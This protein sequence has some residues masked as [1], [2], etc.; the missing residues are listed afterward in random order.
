MA[1]SGNGPADE[2]AD[3]N[4][5]GTTMPRSTSSG[6]AWRR[7]PCHP[8]WLLGTQRPEAAV[9]RLPGLV[10]DVGCADRWV[11]RCRDPAGGYVGLDYPATGC[12]L[13]AARPDLFAD[14]SALPV[15][16]ASVDAVVC[17]EVLEHL[18]RPRAALEEMARV[19]KPGGTLLLSMPFLYPVHD[20][21]FDFQ[22]LTVHGLRRDLEASGF[23]LVRLDKRGHAVRAAGLLLS[24]SL[25]GGLHARRRW[26][27]LLL[28]P[29]ALLGVTVVNLVATVLSWMLP[30]WDAMASG[31]ELE[32]RRNPSPPSARPVA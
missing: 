7:L 28:A 30:D 4:N 26:H 16:T 18:R 5:D 14:A 24:L 32:A 12:D 15:A 21:P 2:R 31:Y 6:S 1:R 17:L 19:L 29:F 20:A 10:L 25:V 3:R 9:A 11:E 23:E 27:D 22:R 13:Y 8:Q